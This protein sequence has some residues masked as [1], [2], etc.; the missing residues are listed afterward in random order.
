MDVLQG[1]LRRPFSRG[2]I[3]RLRISVRLPFFSLIFFPMRL[4]IIHLWTGFFLF[5]FVTISS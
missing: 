3:L 2:L 1:G 5:S 4:V